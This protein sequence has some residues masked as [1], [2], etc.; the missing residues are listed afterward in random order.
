MLY[1]SKKIIII[2][3][4]M[5]WQFF[6]LPGIENGIEYRYFSRYRIEV[7]NSSIV[8]TLFGADIGWIVCTLGCRDLLCSRMNQPFER[9]S[10]K[11]SNLPPLNGSLSFIFK[12]A[13]Q[14][15][16]SINIS[17]LHFLYLKH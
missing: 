12:V 3:P 6:S 10:D 14:L 1:L 4:L 8:T 7:R 9:F 2:D 5:L 17:I 16:K 13:F 11:I 15:F